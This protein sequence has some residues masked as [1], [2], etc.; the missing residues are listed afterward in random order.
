M[1]ERFIFPLLATIGLAL[2]L[3]GLTAGA[4]FMDDGDII[5][6]IRLRATLPL[7][8]L[9]DYR[10]QNLYFRPLL[11]ISY[12]IDAW[13]WDLKPAAMHLVNILLHVCN[14]TLIYLCL[15]Q[16]YPSQHKK[17][18]IQPLTG[19]ILFL[20][21]PINTESVNWISG[22]S[23][24]LAALFCL[25]ATWIIVKLITTPSSSSLPWLA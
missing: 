14:A 13:L 5:N 21:H 24:P 18:R 2:F 16:L 9:F 17:I 19:A 8:E 11:T 4:F 1:R 7:N 22:R 10:G 3:P 25:L 12:L 6:S 20:I 23:D 15:R